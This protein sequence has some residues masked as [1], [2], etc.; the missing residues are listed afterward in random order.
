MWLLIKGIELVYMQFK[1]SYWFLIWCGLKQLRGCKHVAIICLEVY[2]FL[3]NCSEN[4]FKKI[5]CDVSLNFFPSSV[6]GRVALFSSQESAFFAAPVFDSPPLPSAWGRAFGCWS[7]LFC[8][9]NLDFRRTLLLCS[10][11][12]LL[13]PDQST[14]PSPPTA[15]SRGYLLKK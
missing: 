8:L 14:N 7:K 15:D 5:L 1:G 9:S 10:V 2:D 13:I 11:P 6:S 12:V 4:S 3:I